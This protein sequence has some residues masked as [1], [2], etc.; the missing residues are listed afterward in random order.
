MDWEGMDLYQIANTLF[1]APEAK[2]DPS[3]AALARDIPRLARASGCRWNEEGRVVY[4]IPKPDR[5]ALA[6][7][8]AV[9]KYLSGATAAIFGDL[10]VIG[11]YRP[12]MQLVAFAVEALHLAEL[13]GDMEYFENAD[14][15]ILAASID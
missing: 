12:T 14:A 2:N 13:D 1:P 15:V 8:G 6:Q 10:L 9:Q 5:Y 11:I 3:L 7:L 4:L